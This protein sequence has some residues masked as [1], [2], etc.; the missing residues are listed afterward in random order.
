[1][2]LLLL[3]FKLLVIPVGLGVLATEVANDPRLGLM[4]MDAKALA[5][6]LLVNQVALLLF[7]IRMQV[8]LRVFGI[9]LPLGQSLRVHLQSMFYFFVL[10]MTVGL[11][12]ARFTKIRNLLGAKANVNALG[13]ALLG[14]RVV[15]AVAAL[16][17]ALALVPFVDFQAAFQWRG[18][19][20]ALW[21]AAAGIGIAAALS[22]HARIRAHIKQVLDLCRS[23]RRG[24]WTSLMVAMLTHCCFA[25]GIYLAA[26]GANLQISFVQ[27]LFAIS[28]AMLF[29]VLPVSFAGVSPVEAAGLGVLMGMGIPA[30]R[31]AIFV[32]ISYLA[33]LVAAFEGGGW[34]ILEG[35]SD[36]S[37]LLA[38][39]NDSKS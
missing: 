36:A 11:E 33:K 13:Y 22:M 12:L 2:R 35:G 17:L 9:K 1:M 28:A 24:L 15:G 38:A 8:T 32:L 4:S 34:E 29:V 27:S 14:D 10:P 37:R 30:D 18:V 23:A 16:I 25:F 26:A 31:A 19:S 7:A 6:A 20:P 5:A 3:L 39:R 21:W